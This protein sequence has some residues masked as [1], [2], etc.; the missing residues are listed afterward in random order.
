MPIH[1]I[2]GGARSGKSHHAEKLAKASG[3][4]VSVIVTAEGLDEEMRLRIERHRLDR[5]TDWRTV[6]CPLHLADALRTESTPG[7]CVIV[8]C[9]TLW[10]ANLLGDADRQ[11]HPSSIG[12]LTALQRERAALMAA[13]PQLPGEII[14]VANEVGL[15]LVPETPLGRLFRDEAGR[16]NQTLA[17]LSDKVSFVA[18]GLSLSLK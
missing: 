13:L 10:L 14:L 3:L 4:P 1:L 6:E 18:A 8:D 11:P 16:L 5:P 2:L 12:A 15:G 9:L 7:R 17:A